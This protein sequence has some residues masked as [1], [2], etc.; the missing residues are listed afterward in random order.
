MPEPRWNVLFLDRPGY[1]AA[2]Q[3]LPEFEAATGIK[4]NYHHRAV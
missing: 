2:I 3:M 1:N 4:V